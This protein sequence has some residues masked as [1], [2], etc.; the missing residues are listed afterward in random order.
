MAAFDLS[1]EELQTYRPPVPEPQGFDEFWEDTLAEAKTF[2]S[3]VVMEPVETG[4]RA[5]RT[6]DVVFPGFGGHPVHAWLH[7]PAIPA[8]PGSLPAV[9]QYQGYG[10][11]RALAH[12]NILWA[13]A[14]Y[15][16]LVCDTR[17]QGSGWSTGD[18][19]DPVGSAPAHPGFMTRGI[20]DP[21]S[22][23]YRRVFVDAFRAIE[24][25]RGRDEV[26]G[27]RVAVVGA[28]QGGGISLAVAGLQAEI[29][30]VMVDVPFLCNFPRALQL[31]DSDPY[32]EVVRYLK[33]HRDHREQALRTLSYFD[34]V[35]FSKRSDV[36]ALFSVAL[37]DEICP[38]ST[39]YS[40]Y[41]AYAGPK[42]IAVYHYNDHEG[43]EAFHEAEQ[44]R[45]L[46]ARLIQT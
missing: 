39:V 11:G 15:A 33:V 44:L 12:E 10:G 43:G 6:W 21:R 28:S 29:A 19:P 20:L 40:A 18:T 37:M 38:P 26:D 32:G 2:D 36:P 30:A 24:V 23:Y 34:G 42:E 35:N 5:V 31:S 3:D 9:V 8:D 27:S 46:H 7:L 16:H 4:I 17:G 25:V 1:L 14:G 13:A 45:W 41:N 22:Y